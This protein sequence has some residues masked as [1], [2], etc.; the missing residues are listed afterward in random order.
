MYHHFNK[1]T[2]Y[3]SEHATTLS[4]TTLLLPTHQRETRLA[5]PTSS[6]PTSSPLPSLSSKPGSKYSLLPEQGSAED[7][8]ETWDK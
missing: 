1:R 5:S 7:D 8:E 4:D 2:A 3:P 6:P